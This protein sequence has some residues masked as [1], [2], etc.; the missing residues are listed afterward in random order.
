[1][2]RIAWLSVWLVCT[3]IVVGAQ[4][5]TYQG[6]LK[7]NG[8]PANGSYDFRFRLYS[9]PDGSNQVGSAIFR[10]NVSVERGLFTVSLDFGSVWTGES[11]YLEISVRRA[12]TGSY[13]V[14][15]PL[16]PI[17]NTPYAIFA[18][19]AQSAQQVP[20]SGIT[21][22]PAGF[23]DGID[24][25]TTYSAGAG[26]QLSGNTFSIAPEGIV[27]N[28][29]ANSSVT[30]PKI[31][32]GAVTD[33]KLSNT[34]VTA[35]TY[36]S[37]NQVGVFTVN[38]QGR[39]TSA[40]NV[41]ISGVS[42]GGAA[43]GD[44]GGSYPNPTVVGLQG[45]PV[46]ST[47][48]ANEQVLK[49]NGT[50]WA[51]ANEIW[52]RSGSNIFYTSG[53]VGIGTNN[54][55][56]PI[57]VDSNLTR[58]IV[59]IA[60]GTYSGGAA[61]I[62]RATSTS[63]EYAVHGVSGSTESP[64]GAG[65][66][67]HNFATTGG[68]AGGWFESDSNDYG[69]GVHGQARGTSLGS[70]AVRGYHIASNGNGIGVEGRVNSPDGVGVRGLG[71]RNGTFG[72]AFQ[73]SGSTQGVL[74]QAESSNPD[75]Y[76]VMCLGRFAASGSKSF[77]IDHPL[78]PETHFLNHFCTEGP[79]PYNA[80]SGVVELDA[81]GEAWVQLPDYFEAI[82]RE[83]RYLL[84]PIG[85]P[86][87]NLHVAVEIHGNRFK[88]AGGAPGKRVSWRVEAIRNDLWVQRY[89]YRTEV[90]KPEAEKGKY[91]HPELYGL[92]KEK[93]LYYPIATELG[94]HLGETTETTKP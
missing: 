58:A 74:G 32:S 70:Y 66:S 30:T 13:T 80:Y 38:A 7:E 52:Q 16:V 25:D 94:P 20:W 88:I 75:G 41:T 82:N 61:I 51:P 77:R 42:P 33:E 69:I 86:M 57:T 29:L 79:A 22:M 71:P 11:R 24:N 49:W 2:T 44:L 64:R 39:I 76:G 78:Y 48:P 62:G 18:R 81:N 46:S 40:S 37:A 4:P 55:N 8:N 9:D 26:L 34:G 1:M 84:T 90:E 91:L 21:G 28:M 12:G 53:Y 23:A 54:P 17:T 92:P 31:A 15:S 19:Q 35:G 3:L 73:R 50:Q 60:R 45:R 59:G 72:Y 6:F 43:G 89:G 10:A 63:S 65:V 83:P 5:F 68:S 93:G 85:A 67:G 56:T 87:P 36:G 14:L 27:S 47:P